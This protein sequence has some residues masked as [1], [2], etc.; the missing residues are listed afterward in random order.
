MM[1][2]SYK[3][4]NITFC[5]VLIIISATVIIYTP[6][7]PLCYDVFGYYMYLPLKFKYHDLKVQ[8]FSVITHIMN[9][10]HNSET[11][12]QALQWENGNWI[13]RYPI[14]LAVLLSPFYFLADFIVQ[15]TGYPADGFSK[16]YQLCILY[17][18][19]CYAIIG[20]YFLKKIVTKFFD[21]ITSAI[22]FVCITLGTNYFLHVSIHGQGIMSHNFVFVLY[23]A[24]IYFTVKWH[25][26]FKNIYIICLA[27]AIG[28]I[29]LCRPTEIISVL[30]PL[31]YGVTNKNTFLQKLKLLY[32]KKLQLILLTAIVVS[33]G[34]IQFGYWYYVSG[35]FIINPYDAGNPGEG[36][37]LLQPHI[38]EVLFSFRKGWFI[39]TPLMLFTV[40]GF[41]HL[42]KKNRAMFTP[43]FIYF[44]INLYIVSCWSCWWYGACFGVRSLVPSYAALIVPL[45]Y[46]ISYVLGSKFKYLFL[47]LS[48]LLISL[49]LFQSWQMAKG[50]MDSTNMSRAY[51]FSTFLQTTPPT[52]E[53]VKLLLKG[54]FNDGKE[55]F[56]EED[57]LTHSLCFSRSLRFEKDDENLNP[58][59]W[60]DTIKHTGNFSLLTNP[61]NPFSKAIEPMIKDVTSKSYAWVKSTVWLYS[62][63][64]AD[65]L[66]W[67]LILELRHKRRTFKYKG[68]SI[69]RTTFKSNAWNKIEFYLL[70]PDDLRSREDEVRT[71]FWNNCKYDIFVDDLVMEAFEPIIDKSV[72]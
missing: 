26:S 5:I 34:F 13:M 23:A 48:G 57:A 58:K 6:I 52:S 15:Y 44:I 8:D 43:V 18:G 71:Y 20:L 53:Q 25:E 12:Y 4:T 14:G 30:I 65:S 9:T 19:L 27:L 21:D 66:N 68:A 47:A 22:A 24:I 1:Q 33:I 50:I 38:L 42:Y 67:G 55:I 64:P 2:T 69:D 72:F 60:S 59:F 45:G 17:G 7:N 36:L 32:T 28:F 46:F 62:K 11:F 56:T 10:Y 39:Y 31:F 37:E 40:I 63:F 61:E 29:A 35:E 3:I 41:W 16:P 54:K 51:Y 49:N 70:I